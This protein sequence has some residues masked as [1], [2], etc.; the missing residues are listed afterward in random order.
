MK[1][2][3]KFLPG[4]YVGGLPELCSKAKLV[5]SSPSIGMNT[6]GHSICAQSLRLLQHKATYPFPD[7]K[8]TAD[9]LQEFLKLNAWGRLTQIISWKRESCGCE[10]HFQF[11]PLCNVLESD[12]SYAHEQLDL[13]TQDFIRMQFK[14]LRRFV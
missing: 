5:Q 10:S 6:N 2:G 9:C 7:C 13:V 11:C 14:I 1:K 4:N 12:F 3:W 8:S